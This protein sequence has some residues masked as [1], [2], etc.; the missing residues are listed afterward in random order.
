MDL[1]NEW[2]LARGRKKEV[3]GK[4]WQAWHEN[5]ADAKSQD[6]GTKLLCGVTVFVTKTEPQASE[7]GIEM[8]SPFYMNIEEAVT[9]KKGDHNTVE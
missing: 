9:S 5:S 2:E 8:T 1:K 4:L 3:S 7:G 6:P